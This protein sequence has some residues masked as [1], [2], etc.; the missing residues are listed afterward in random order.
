[1]LQR[2]V[3]GKKSKGKISSSSMNAT[4]ETLFKIDR[5]IKTTL[6]ITFNVIEI[7]NKT[8]EN[9]VTYCCWQ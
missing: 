5:F 4:N 7:T 2:P 6:H 1:M 3:R 8:V 9:N